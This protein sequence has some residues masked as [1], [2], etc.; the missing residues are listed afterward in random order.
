MYVIVA[1]VVALKTGSRG[2]MASAIRAF[3]AIA[4][5]LTLAI[6]LLFYFLILGD[7]R[8]AYVATY[9]SLSLWPL[10]TISALW[11]GQEGS[12]LLWAWLL[13]WCGIVVLWRVRN[14]AFGLVKYNA[15]DRRHEVQ[16]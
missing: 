4:A 8:L 1:S 2:W 13:S 5:L 3:Y 10:Y 6:L 15:T 16:K 7:F 11:A 14:Y 9:T 12:L